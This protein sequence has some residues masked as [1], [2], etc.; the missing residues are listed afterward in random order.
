MLTEGLDENGARPPPTFAS[1]AVLLLAVAPSLVTPRVVLD[2]RWLG[3]GGTGRLTELLVRGLAALRPETGW[4]LWGPPPVQDLAWPGSDAE[5]APGDP[6][7]ALGQRDWFRIPDADLVV[8]MH[9]ARPLRRVPAVTVILDTIPLRFG[10]TTLGRLAKRAFLRS[11]AARSRR[12]V[13]VSEHSRRCITRD[14][15]VAPDRISIVHPPVDRDLVERVRALRRDLSEPCPRALYI[16]NFKA[17][18]NLSRLVEAFAR[19]DF[20]RAGGRLLLVGGTPAQVRELSARLTDAE[21][22]FLELRAWCSQQE[23]ERLLATSLF[24]AQPSLEEGFGLPAW[25]ALSCGLPLCLSDGGALSEITGALVER[26][27]A[28]SVPEMARAVDACADRARHRGPAPAR[29]LPEGPRVRDFALEFE[30]VV[31]AALRA[32]RGPG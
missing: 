8:F 27:P 26:F 17:H 9:Q 1:L 30:A 20:R 7:R 18:K 29:P 3:I 28:T 4:V 21:R 23:L 14:L 16:G 13:T 19:T 31:Q 22:S 25:E 11:V 32:D 15:G 2:C 24:V 6:R 12:V 5:I 10:G